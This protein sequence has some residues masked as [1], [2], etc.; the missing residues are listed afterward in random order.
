MSSVSWGEV[1]GMTEGDSRQMRLEPEDGETLAVFLSTT[2]LK[3]K[4]LKI[5]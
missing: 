3:S 1:R 5:E 2:D 4:L